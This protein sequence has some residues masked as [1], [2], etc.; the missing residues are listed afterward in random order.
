MVGD[1][2]EPD[3][4]GISKNKPNNWQKLNLTKNILRHHLFYLI[5]KDDNMVNLTYQAHN[6]GYWLIWVQ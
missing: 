3:E 6:L 5:L 4:L 2:I 1:P